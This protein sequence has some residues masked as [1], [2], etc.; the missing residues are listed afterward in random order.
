MDG[1]IADNTDRGIATVAI[2]ADIVLTFDCQMRNS[3]TN[4]Y[5]Q[6]V[7]TL[8]VG[9]TSAGITEVARSKSFGT[10]IMKSA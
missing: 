4:C 3:S 8:T 1:V 6:S 2:N 10:I 5:R 9:G 7:E